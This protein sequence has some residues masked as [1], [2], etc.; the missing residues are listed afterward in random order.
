MGRPQSCG[1]PAFRFLPSEVAEMEACLNQM[2]K[3]APNR[4]VL[5]Q[6]LA[7]KF[8]ASP[9]RAGMVA[10]QPKQVPPPLVFLPPIVSYRIL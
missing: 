10:I 3:R 7:D 5:L 1:A 6:S 2:K 4:A 8:S 9:E